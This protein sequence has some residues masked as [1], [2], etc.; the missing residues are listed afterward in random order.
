MRRGMDDARADRE[1]GAAGRGVDFRALFEALPSPHMV[2]D[3]DLNFVE[4]NAA[5]CAVTERRRDELIGRNMFDLFPNPGPEGQR[6]RQSL[7]RVLATGTPDVLALIPYPI[8][9]S[10]HA[11]GALELRYWSAVH[12]PLFDAEGRPAYVVQNTVDVTE[13][14]QLKAIAYGADAEPQ[15]GETDLFQRT[16]QVEETNR[17]LRAET[18]GLRD[19]FLQAPGFVAVVGGPELTFTLANRAYQQLIGH[20]PIIGKPVAEALP[21]VRGQ[22]F[23]RLLHQVVATGEPFIGHAVSVMLQRAPHAPLEERFLDFVYQPITSPSGERWGV[24]V[25]GGDVTDR[26]HAERQQKLL[27]DELNHRVKNTLATVQAIASQTLRSNPDPAAFRA[28]FEAR[29]QAL[30]ATHSLLTGS[31][32][33]SAALKDLLLNELRPYDPR[34]Y[35]LDGPPLPLVAGQALSLGLVFH[36]LATNAAKYGALAG[37][38]GEVAVCWR[39]DGPPEAR[40]LHLDWIERGGPPVAA[41]K[42]RGFGSRLIESSLRSLDGKATADYAPEGLRCSLDLPLDEAG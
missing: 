15:A 32:W 20:R 16:R 2:L 5:Y 12:V 19:L 22:G 35:R 6:L 26:V 9:R 39:V 24:F 30:S 31:G 8:Q 14:Q 21:E 42:R 28:A 7:E 40:R 10:A 23:I 11:G 3:R 29:L 38:A 18:Q 1:R 4:A 34:R 41:P 13:L 36:E 33:R 17:A 37:A 25:Q 27:L